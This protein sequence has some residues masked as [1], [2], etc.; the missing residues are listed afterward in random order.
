MSAAADV[1]CLGGKLGT[2][3]LTVEFKEFSFNKGA[4][5]EAYY[6]TNTIIEYV[7][8]GKV[9]LDLN[10]III[11]NLKL[12]FESYVPKY[13]GVFG[14]SDFTESGKFYIGVNDIG[15]ITGVPFVGEL[16]IETVR[17]YLISTCDYIESKKHDC[18][19]LVEDLDIELIK[20]NIIPE[21]ID[22]DVAEIIEDYKKK[23]TQWE[24]E[25]SEYIAVRTEWAKRMAKFS[26]A[27]IKYCTDPELRGYI[28]N[29]LEENTSPEL[30]ARFIAE[31]ESIKSSDDLDVC[32]RKD[33][34]DDLMYWVTKCK[35]SLVD[36]AMKCKPARV[37]YY[38]FS[39]ARILQFTL[40]T[41]LRARFIKSGLVNYYLIKITFPT[42]LYDIYYKLGKD[43]KWQMKVRTTINGSPGCM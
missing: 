23:K 25:Y 24:A 5:P 17:E 1:F 10:R 8:S 21:L 31:L 38:S 3:E 32:A 11:A 40:L 20:L 29:F 27:I 37:P 43:D 42:R 19:K 12:Y 16:T 14:N 41:N 2:E 35:D 18:R 22:D 15:E 26:C 34:V 9:D 4:T 39:D 7:D 36:A 13:I 6:D 28:K 30:S 33:N